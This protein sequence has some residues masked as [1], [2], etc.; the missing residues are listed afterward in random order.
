[1]INAVAFRSLLIPLRLRVLLSLVIVGSWKD[2]V[3][4]RR[5]LRHLQLGLAMTARPLA[6]GHLDLCEYTSTSEK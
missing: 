5:S 4:C 2:L 6:A 3:I 1:M